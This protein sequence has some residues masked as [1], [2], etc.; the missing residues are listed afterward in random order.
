M[1]KRNT[2]I[3]NYVN[4]EILKDFKKMQPELENMAYQSPKPNLKVKNE[5]LVFKPRRKTKENSP[6]LKS[7]KSTF[8]FMETELNCK[9]SVESRKIIPESRQ[10]ES[11]T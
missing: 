8:R 9:Y 4:Q 2:N 11:V 1:L 5:M 10:G 6:S 7:I 3:Q